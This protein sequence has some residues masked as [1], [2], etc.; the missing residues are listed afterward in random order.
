MFHC[1][2]FARCVNYHDEPAPVCGLALCRDYQA[3]SFA[4]CVFAARRVFIVTE[5]LVR[6]GSLKLLWSVCSL[7]CAACVCCVVRAACVVPC[8]QFF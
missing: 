5:S 3:E 2:D 7:Q 6:T 4:A 8:I 1:V